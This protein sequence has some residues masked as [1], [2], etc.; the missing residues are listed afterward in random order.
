MPRDFRLYLRD[1][2]DEARFIEAHT[3]GLT[4]DAFV[5]N[6]VLVRAVLNSLTVLGE[7]ARAMP[8]EIRLRAPEIPW[9]EMADVRNIIVH[10]YFRVNL[11]IIWDIVEAEIAPLRRRAEQL[12]VDLDASPP[13]A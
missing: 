4:F 2:I 9:R 8:H 7:A 1:M 10:G 11:P 3:Q 12:L 5:A 6:E 13:S